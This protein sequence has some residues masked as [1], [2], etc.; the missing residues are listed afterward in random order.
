MRPRASSCAAYVIQGRFASKDSP[1]KLKAKALQRSRTVAIVPAA[2]RGKRL[3]AKVKKPFVLLK[4]KP[5]VS[6]ALRT[7]N[8]SKYID[9]IIIAAERS[10]VNSFKSLVRQFKLKKV[11]HIVVGGRTRYDSVKNFLTKTPP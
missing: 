2:G 4:G 7:L 3:G 11:I 8:S 9:A 1:T 5:L 6:Y 10:C